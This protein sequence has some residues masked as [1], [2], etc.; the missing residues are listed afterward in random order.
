MIKGSKGDTLTDIRKYLQEEL[1]LSEILGNS[2]FDIRINEDFAA[3][4]SVDSYNKC[5][6]EAK[7]SDFCLVLYNGA[8]GWA[9]KGVE[10][11]IC[12]AEFDAA[13]NVST[14][15][16][17]V[18]DISSFF[19]L[20][21]VKGDEAKRNKKFN[22]YLIELNTFNNPLKLTK[23]TMSNDGFKEE[24]LKMTKGVV[25]NHLQDRLSISNV[26]Y[27]LASNNKKALDWKKLK[28]SDR[29]KYIVDILTGLLSVNPD[30]KDFGYNVSS[31]PDNMSVSDAKAYAGRPFLNDQDLIDSKKPKPGPLHFI[32][33]YGN[34]TETQ[35]KNLLGYPDVSLIK[36]EFGLYVWEQNTHIQ[37][38]FLSNCRT[39]EAIE[40]NL[41]LFNNW[42]KSSDEYTKISKRGE[43]RFHILKSIL[44]AKGIAN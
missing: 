9:P 30:F 6:E 23:S 1:E 19:D 36:D 21:K 29:D 42:C 44:E 4:T 8:A 25:F 26:Y 2:I 31:I 43:A 5:L 22:D 7:E 38:V 24:L 37:M 33:V 13:L 3:D 14:K 40:A 39:P 17:A 11:G 20:S 16:V 41:L 15:K 34:A 32:G 10:L 35:A 27:N 18:I 12:H 28:Y